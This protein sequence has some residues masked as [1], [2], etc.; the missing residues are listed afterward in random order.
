MVDRLRGIKNN[1]IGCKYNL[2]VVLD[3]Y[4]RTKQGTR[5]L[6]R[7]DCG[8]ETI[9]YGH[10]LKNGNTKSCGCLK[11]KPL[12]SETKKKISKAN[13]KQIKFNCDYCRKV[14]FKKRSSFSRN[15]RHFCSKRCYSKFVVERMTYE[16]MNAYKGIRKPGES[17]QIYHRRYVKRN[18][19]RIAHLKARRYARERN[20][21]GSHTL[22]EW[23]ELKRKFNNKCAHCREEKKL[24][25]DH[26][27]PLSKGGTD[28]ITNIQPLCRNCNSKKWANE[29]PELLEGETNV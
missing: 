24:T 27:I 8:K 4:D 9:V 20:A 1:L 28:Y 23:K 11:R 22:E 17:K 2:L 3:I 13:N 6:C 15:E 21:K 10:K 14:S 19:E 25:K 18:P 29:N 26:I 5:R 12:S 7:C 16:E